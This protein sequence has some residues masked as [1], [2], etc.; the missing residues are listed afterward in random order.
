MARAADMDLLQAWTEY[1]HEMTPLA[2]TLFAG[3][4]IG[5][6]SIFEKSSS[7]TLGKGLLG[8]RVVNDEN[9]DQRFIVLILRSIITL[10]N[11][12]SLGLFSWFDLQNKVT[13]SRIIRND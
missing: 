6:F 13:G 9:K 4:Y 12:L 1:P 8:I 5:Y 3:F 7:S 10:A 11:F 2:V